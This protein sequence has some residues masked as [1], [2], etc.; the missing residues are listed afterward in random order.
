MRPIF[1]AS[2]AKRGVLR[3][4]KVGRGGDDFA[5][6]E[7][8]RLDR[9]L[10][11]PAVDLLA[12]FAHGPTAS[13]G[14]SNSFDPMLSLAVVTQRV[15]SASARPNFRAAMALV[16]GS[17]NLIVEIGAST[18]GAK[19]L[20]MSRSLRQPLQDEARHQRAGPVHGR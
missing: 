5:Q 7:G 18:P 14:N 4:L 2:A 1:S 3:A 6:R 15:N 20:A 16:L 8:H 9:G 13:R 17:A 11:G 19:S 10:V 12:Y